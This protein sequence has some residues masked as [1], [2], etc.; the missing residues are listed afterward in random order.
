MTLK[1]GIQH[2]VLNYYHIF[3]NDDIGLT[4]T[5]F[6]TW[7]NLFLNASAWVKSY[8]AYS[9]VFPRA[10]SNSAYPMHSDEQCRTIGPL[11]FCFFFLFLF[12]CCCCCCCF[13]FVVVVFYYILFEFYD[14]SRL[15]HSL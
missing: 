1:R 10:C 14:P 15:F 11:F 13:L 9:N 7:L 3:S 5:V 2:W 12:F 4:L 8:T 6:M